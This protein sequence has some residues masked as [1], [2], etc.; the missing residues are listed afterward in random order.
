MTGEESLPLSDIGLLLWCYWSIESF[1]ATHHFSVNHAAGRLIDAGLLTI[2]GGRHEVTDR[3]RVYVEA[4][5]ALPL[6]QQRWLM[7]VGDR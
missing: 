6:P 1:P 3:G 7:P 5:R 2:G 4:I